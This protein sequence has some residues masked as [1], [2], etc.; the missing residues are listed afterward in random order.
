MT[1]VEKSKLSDN[2]SD[3]EF[4]CRCGCGSM[5]VDLYFL[6]ALE[7]LRSIENRPVHILSG[8]RCPRHNKAIGGTVGSL[9]L[10]SKEV[11]CRAGD[12][13]IAG[14]S[15]RR[16]FGLARQV[17][18]LKGG[19]IGV[20]PGEGFIHVDNRDGLARWAR[21]NKGDGYSKIPR[22]FY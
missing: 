16:M 7:E 2:F 21:L 12:I 8:C 4:R 19:G 13:V 5:W 15:V 1:E 22:N 20:Y 17:P 6:E 3:W 10:A 11:P 14:L 9:H 18:A